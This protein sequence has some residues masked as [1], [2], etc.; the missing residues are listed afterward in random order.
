MEA[1]DGLIGYELTFSSMYSPRAIV[2]YV[3]NIVYTNATL[4]KSK[5]PSQRNRP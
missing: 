4:D 2:M 5:F 1:S 3:V